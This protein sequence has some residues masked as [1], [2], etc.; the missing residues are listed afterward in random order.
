VKE[1]LSFGGC[2]FFSKII[3]S[4]FLVGVGVVIVVVIVVMMLARSAPRVAVQEAQIGGGGEEEKG[5]GGVMKKYHSLSR[6]ELQAL[7]KEY[8]VPANKSNLAMAQ[9]LAALHNTVLYTPHFSQPHLSFFEIINKAVPFFICIA[10]YP[11][12]TNTFLL[13]NK[14][15][16]KRLHLVASSSPQHLNLSNHS[17][18]L[19]LLGFEEAL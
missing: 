2:D 1:R 11:N 8:H 12:A 9:A 3:W 17:L 6:R 15:A 19:Q 13:Q 18:L 10:T 16:Q 14:S 5:A 4:L 7:C